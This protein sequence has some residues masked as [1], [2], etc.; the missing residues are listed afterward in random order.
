MMI[1]QTETTPG[2]R[3]GGREA[4]RYRSRLRATEADRDTVTARLERL[5]RQLVQRVAGKRLQQGRDLLD[6]GGVD[7]DSLRDEVGN[8]DDDKI[9][10]AC[11]ALIETRPGLADAPPPPSFDGGMRNQTVSSGSDYSRMLRGH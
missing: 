6:L 4:A 10:H 8:L 2:D 9:D 1:E 11:D 3:G 7:L 5:E